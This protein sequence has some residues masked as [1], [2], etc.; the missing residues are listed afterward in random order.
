MPGEESIQLLHDTMREHPKDVVVQRRGCAHG[1]LIHAP[2]P[3]S[4]NQPEHGVRGTASYTHDDSNRSK[5]AAKNAAPFGAT[6]LNKQQTNYTIYVYIDRRF[7]NRSVQK[8]AVKI[9]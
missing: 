3:D 7:A 4:P 6:F 2:N 8:I 9:P 1:R 5:Y